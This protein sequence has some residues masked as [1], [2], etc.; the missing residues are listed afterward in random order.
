MDKF[1]NYTK[2]LEEKIRKLNDLI[3]KLEE[4]H[5]E[6][7]R[8]LAGT[9][10]EKEVIQKQVDNQSISPDDVERMHKE[11][12]QITN[13]RNSIAAKMKE[14]NKLKWEK[15]L[16]FEKEVAE[17]ENLVQYYNTSLYRVGLL[18]SNAKYA[19]GENYELSTD[20]N[21]DRIDKM[22]SLDLRDTVK[23]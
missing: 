5:K 8:Q 17:V 14:I 15:G 13:T 1:N 21:A 7:E 3:K 23:V 2:H 11:S 10:I 9:E 16:E 22:I 6:T 20:V 4:Q 12:E 18:P 19:N